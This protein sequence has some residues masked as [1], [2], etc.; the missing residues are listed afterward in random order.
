MD[1]WL[2]AISCLI[3][4]ASIASDKNNPTLKGVSKNNLLLIQQS[5]SPGTT[6]YHI[7]VITLPFSLCTPW[8]CLPSSGSILR[9]FPFGVVMTTKLQASLLPPFNLGEKRHQVTFPEVSAKVPF[10]FIAIVSY[11]H[12]GQ[13]IECFD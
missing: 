8:L 7:A 10:H 2:F 3:S 6:C 5:Q 11:A 1:P 12:C 9:G 4:D 13:R